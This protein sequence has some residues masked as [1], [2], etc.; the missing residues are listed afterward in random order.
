[1]CAV[2]GYPCALDLITW[3]FTWPSRD[4][5]LWH[6]FWQFRLRVKRKQASLVSGAYHS[7]EWNHH[8]LT[9]DISYM[10]IRVILENSRHL[11]LT[12]V[13][14]CENNQHL[15]T[16]VRVVWFPSIT[17]RPSLARFWEL[18]RESHTK[19]KEET[20]ETKKFDTAVGQVSST[21][22]TGS[23]LGISKTMFRLNE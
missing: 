19:D 7:R 14:D 21:P 2:T 18:P 11:S 4:Q 12:P 10:K 6:T 22:P 5:I 16:S 1:M 20:L 9:L 15:L 23:Q 3:P 8:S 17:T 13:S